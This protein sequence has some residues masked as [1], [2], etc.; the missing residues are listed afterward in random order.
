VGFSQDR[1][2]LDAM[3]D[4]MVA[5]T[6]GIRDRLTDFARAVT[7]AYYFVPASEALAAFAAERT[8]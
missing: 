8:G 6:G 4:S 1:A 5:R 2:R 7:S 3:L